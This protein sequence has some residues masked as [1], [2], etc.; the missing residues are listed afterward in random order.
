M[1]ENWAT[2]L[3]HLREKPFLVLQ[4]EFQ[5]KTAAPPAVL[6]F[7]QLKCRVLVQQRPEI[8]NIMCFYGH[9]KFIVDIY[10]TSRS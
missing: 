2:M 10:C 9:S 7:Y 4:L 3:R 1:L 5:R 8:G 6:S